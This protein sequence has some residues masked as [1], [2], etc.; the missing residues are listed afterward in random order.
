[1]TENRRQSER[2]SAETRIGKT[3]KKTRALLVLALCLSLMI[4]LPMYSKAADTKTPALQ[5]SKNPQIQQIK[6]KRPVKIKLHR[7]AKGEY[8]WDISGDNVDEIVRAD[9]R[10]KKLLQVEGK[11]EQK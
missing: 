10:L 8:Q 2:P 11:A 3:D 6:P 4:I 5:F 7:T 9:Q 1:M